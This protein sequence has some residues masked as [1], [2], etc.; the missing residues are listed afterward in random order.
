[1]IAVSTKISLKRSHMA[2]PADKNS[3]K[4]AAADVVKE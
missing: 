2:H 4:T 3:L 1:M